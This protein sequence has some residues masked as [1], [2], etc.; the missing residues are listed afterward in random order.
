MNNQTQSILN[1]YPETR[2]NLSL[3]GR[4][5]Q[6]RYTDAFHVSDFDID[7]GSLAVEA[8]FSFDVH[9]EAAD[10]STGYDA[11]DWTVSGGITA[12]KVS[13]LTIRRNMSD[14]YSCDLLN[15]IS[16]DTRSAQAD[17]GRYEQILV[18]RIEGEYKSGDRVISSNF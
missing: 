17:L 10:P 1:Q 5:R 9:Y 16:E 2:A 6:P 13:G 15:F 18:D 4:K 3:S 7:C 12:V 14:P 11:A 8:L